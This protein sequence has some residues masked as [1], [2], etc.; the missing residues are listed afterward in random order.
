MNWMFFSVHTIFFIPDENITLVL[1]AISNNSAGWLLLGI[2]NV[3][4]LVRKLPVLYETPGF[5]IVFVISPLSLTNAKR[6]IY[7]FLILSLL[8][9]FSF[10]NYVPH[11]RY[12]V[13]NIQCISYVKVRG[14]CLVQSVIPARINLIIFSLK[15][16][17]WRFTVSNLFSSSSCYLYSRRP[18]SFPQH[19]DFNS[20]KFCSSSRLT[21]HTT[22][23]C[24]TKDKIVVSYYLVLADRG[25]RAIKC[26]T[27]AA[28]LLGLWVRIPLGAW[29]SVSCECCVLSNRG[30]Y[31]GPIRR[32]EESYRVCMCHWV[33]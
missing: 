7:I 1:S 14:S 10:P 2:P 26:G 24:S 15:Y 19:F 16:K 23:L 5:T 32:P 8:F 22:P 11:F 13:P 20:L 17:S 30:P 18:K 6:I 4:H 21:D 27:A 28:R 31:D 33:W 3:I 29:M 25:G 12:S 9:M